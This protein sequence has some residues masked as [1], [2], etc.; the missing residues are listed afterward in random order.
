MGSA[1]CHLPL[2]SLGT[3]CVHLPPPW[4]AGREAPQY[5]HSF[6]KTQ[7][8]SPGIREQLFGRPPLETS[9]PVPQRANVYPKPSS[10]NLPLLTE[11]QTDFQSSTR[12][13]TCSQAPF[14]QRVAQIRSPGAEAPCSAG[15]TR[16]LKSCFPPPRPGHEGRWA[17]PAPQ[18]AALKCICSS[19]LDRLQ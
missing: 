15:C 4:V 17:H 8:P 16:V 7:M 2:T 10:P 18:R 5:Q 11:R 12:V 9:L 1:S 3:S 19:F 13:T 14:S 6:P